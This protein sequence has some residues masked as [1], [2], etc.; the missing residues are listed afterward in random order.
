MSEILI[1]T[2]TTV[3]QHQPAIAALGSTHFFVVWVDSSDRTIKGRLIQADGNPS[4]DE[5]VVNTPTPLGANMDRQRPTIAS[6]GPGPIVAWIENAVNPP[7]PRPHVKLQRFNQDGQPSGSEIQVSTTDVDPAHR[8]AITGMIDGGF[9]VSWMD[10]RSDQRIRAQRFII[11][12]SKKGPEFRVNTTD[13]FHEAPIATRLVNGNYVIAWRSDPSPPGGGALIFRIFDL[14][15]SPI[16][17]ETRPNLSG[18][19]GQKAMT[20]L[21][22]NDRFVIAHVRGLGNS[23]IGVA[24]SAVEANV[25]ERNGAS[26]NI[27][28]FATSGQ[29]INTSSPTLAPLPGGR[30]LLAWVQKRADTFATIPSVRAR[31]FSGSQGGPVG[32]E[33]QVNTTTTGDRFSARAAAI[34]TPGEGETAFVAWADDSQTG[35]DPSDFAVRGRVLS[36][37]ASGGLG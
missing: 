25:F 32:Q 19:T 29:E 24:K 27:P 20:F 11:D 5:F 10:A 2:T 34:V 22:D 14:E 30:F 26:A 12:G 1:N 33:V 37:L 23:D 36:I 15:G 8:P 31:V 35:G 21:D 28:I 18:F 7:G 3:L 16:V 4:A 6:S 13:G 9:L 17:G